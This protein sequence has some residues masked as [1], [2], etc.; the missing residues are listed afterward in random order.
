MNSKGIIGL[1]MAATAYFGYEL[2]RIVGAAIGGFIIGGTLV[3]M[4][5]TLLTPEKII[6]KSGNNSAVQVKLSAIDLRNNKLEPL[7]S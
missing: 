6:S 1:N 4:I 7:D 2:F 5:Y 3:A